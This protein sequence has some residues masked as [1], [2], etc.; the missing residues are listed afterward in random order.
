MAEAEDVLSAEIHSALERYKSEQGTDAS[1]RAADDLIHLLV[2]QVVQLKTVL[3]NHMALEERK[4]AEMYDILKALKLFLTVLK[5]VA[6]ISASGVAIWKF[7]K[8]G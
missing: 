2:I 7:F 1:R 5:W 6:A 3:H 4:I 8:G